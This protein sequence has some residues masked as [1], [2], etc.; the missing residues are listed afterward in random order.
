MAGRRPGALRGRTQQADELAKWLRLI[1]AG[2]TVRELEAEFHVSK[3]LWSEYRYGSSLPS[4][5]LIT[6]LVARY[7]APDVGELRGQEGRRLLR[8]AHEAAE[9]LPAGG[10][11][12][13]RRYCGSTMPGC[14]RSTPSRDSP[15]PGSTVSGWRSLFP[16][17]S[18]S[19]PGC[20]GK[21]SEARE[22]A[23]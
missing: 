17:S 6:A 14:G 12:G 9:R 20:A 5:E 3:S 7:A 2:R 21:A 23:P 18:R 13:R 15:R 8:A 10:T 1:T 4:A 16:L 19:A 22:E 11:R